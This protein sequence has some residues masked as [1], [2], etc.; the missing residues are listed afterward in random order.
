MSAENPFGGV[1]STTL[2]SVSA[3]LRSGQLT[4]PLSRF[5][6]SQ[7]SLPDGVVAE[8][9]RLHEDGLAVRH[10]ALLLDAKA[11]VHDAAHAAQASCELVW[12]GPEHGLSSSRSTAVVLDEIFRQASR[13]VLVSSFVIQQGDRVF[14]TLASRME[15]IPELAVRLF[16]HVGRG[17]NDTR[18]ESELLRE[19]RDRLIE[20]WPGARKPIVYY[21]PRSLST[22]PDVRAAWH[23]KCAIADDEVALVTSANFTEWAQVRNVEAGVL[24]RNRHFARQ[25]R[26][27]FEALISSR[28]A[29]RMPGL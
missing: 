20:Q 17:P 7:L 18:D 23:A 12:S 13:S 21:D 15:Q 11:E 16:L 24:V 27:Q 29:R 1:S 8:V 19:G 4:E 3:A 25:L 9:L 22:D 5:R 26:E 14:A 6:L 10:L 2:R 28:Q